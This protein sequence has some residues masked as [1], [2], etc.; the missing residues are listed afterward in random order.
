MFQDYTKLMENW[1]KMFN[2]QQS[3]VDFFN[4]FLQQTNIYQDFANFYKN[5]Q[6]SIFNFT[7]FISFQNNFKKFQEQYADMVFKFF[8]L[9]TLN[10][11]GTNNYLN[12]DWFKNFPFFKEDFLKTPSFGLTREYVDAYKKLIENYKIYLEKMNEFK[13]A[14]SEK[15]KEGFEKFIEQ[16]KDAK[17]FEDF[18][19]AFKKW[20]QINE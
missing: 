12:F 7:D 8:G 15:A 18:D 2:F 9:N 16:I 1:Q 3:Q 13:N 6:N 5:L 11:L 4:P 10:L 20:I 14:I 19:N 17:L